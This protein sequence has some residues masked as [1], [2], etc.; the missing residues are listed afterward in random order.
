MNFENHYYGDFKLIFFH[1][2]I[3]YSLFKNLIL[4]FE[5]YRDF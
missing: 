4:N 1:L 2:S 3:L 5:A